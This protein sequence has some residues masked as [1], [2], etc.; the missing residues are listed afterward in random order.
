[1]TTIAYKDGVLASDTRATVRGKIWSDNFPKIFNVEGKGYS[2]CG[3]EVL[4]YATAG[5]VYSQL[6][7]GSI[8][9]QGIQ[10]GSTLDSDDDFQSIVITKDGAYAMSKEDENPNLRIIKIPDGVHWSIGS[11]ADIAGYV[12][13]TGGDAVKAVIE[14]CKVD[15]GSGGE[16]DVWQR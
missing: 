8:L 10:V 14:A 9:E 2:I 16:V 13:L 4:A 12:M 6:S 15:V 5:F 7:V 1:M 3:E 11:G